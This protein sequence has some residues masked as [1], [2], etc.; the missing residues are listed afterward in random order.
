MGM[1]C[2]MKLPGGPL[3]C[4]AEYRAMGL[5]TWARA[6]LIADTVTRPTRCSLERSELPLGW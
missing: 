1:A 2:F 3:L 5:G 6:V 4:M